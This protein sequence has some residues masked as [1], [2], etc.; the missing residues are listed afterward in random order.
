MDGI[1]QALRERG[2]RGHER[3]EGKVKQGM[4]KEARLG[5]GVFVNRFYSSSNSRDIWPHLKRMIS[6]FNAL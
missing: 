3:R 1:E 2:R 5:R 4:F 6:N